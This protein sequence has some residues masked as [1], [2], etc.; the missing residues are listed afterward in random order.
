MKV[1]TGRNFPYHEVL[2]QSLFVVGQDSYGKKAFVLSLIK[3]YL[4][5]GNRVGFVCSRETALNYPNYIH[6]KKLQM[7]TFYPIDSSITLE[8]AEFIGGNNDVIV[9]E[10]GDTLIGDG[11]Y[12]HDVFDCW[13]K[14][15]KIIE[16]S[17]LDSLSKSP[18]YLETIIYRFDGQV[19]FKSNKTFV[20][21]TILGESLSDIINRLNG[22]SIVMTGNTFANEHKGVITQWQNFVKK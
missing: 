13:I 1:I 10:N 6:E 16:Y 9:V 7:L 2:E 8:Y 21:T 14:K 15:V 4:K 3:E 5:H 18:I 20:T 17:L 12:A 19:Y 22:Q 11:E